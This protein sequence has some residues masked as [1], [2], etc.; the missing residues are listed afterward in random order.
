MACLSIIYGVEKSR[1]RTDFMDFCNAKEFHPLSVSGTLLVMV[2]DH[3][4]PSRTTKMRL[5]PLTDHDRCHH[6]DHGVTDRWG[7]C[8]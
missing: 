2:A 8:V 5:V 1:K 3:A 4:H 7:Y 6:A